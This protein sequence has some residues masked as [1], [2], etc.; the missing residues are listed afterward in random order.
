MLLPTTYRM[1]TKLHM[2]IKSA[3]LSSSMGLYA[4]VGSVVQI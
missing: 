1:E 4:F 3:I 2:K